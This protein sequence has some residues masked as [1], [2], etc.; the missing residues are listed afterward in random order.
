MTAIIILHVRDTIYSG[1]SCIAAALLHRK[2][3][4]TW[5]VITA[6]F[7]RRLSR[8]ISSQL[9]RHTISKQSDIAYIRG[10]VIYVPCGRETDACGS[11]TSYPPF[12]LTIFSLYFIVGNQ[13]ACQNLIPL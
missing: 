12:L 1:L 6:S 5:R 8:Q 10:S 9:A 7:T 2:P 3:H 4:V 11:W 13:S